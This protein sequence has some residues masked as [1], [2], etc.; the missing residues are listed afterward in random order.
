MDYF[1]V[2]HTSSAI[3]AAQLFV[4]CSRVLWLLIPRLREIQGC[5]V[6]GG[7]AE[8]LLGSDLFK[9]DQHH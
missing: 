9:L 4:S 3:K 1:F 8:L 5:G 2:L 7:T 6:Q